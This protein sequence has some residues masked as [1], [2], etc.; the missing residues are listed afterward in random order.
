MLCLGFEKSFEG[1]A[2]RDPADVILGAL[3]GDSLGTL[4]GLTWWAIREDIKNDV[5]S[6]DL[7]QCRA[8]EV[9]REEVIA[10]LDLYEYAIGRYLQYGDSS[11]DVILRTTVNQ[12]IELVCEDKGYP[13]VGLKQQQQGVKLAV[14]VAFPGCKEATKMW[15]KE[16]KKWKSCRG[17]SKIKVKKE[18]LERDFGDILESSPG[19]YGELKK[20]LNINEANSFLNEI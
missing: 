4:A 6:R 1:D 18:D 9:G 5:F 8:L 14:Q 13:A 11:K 20:L 16:S 3:E 15:D 19:R 12:L 10:G 17:Y 7:M 2:G